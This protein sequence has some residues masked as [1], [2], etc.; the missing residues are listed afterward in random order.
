M[1]KESATVGV[2]S[3]TVMPESY[4]II[5][6]GRKKNPK[7]MPLSIP[8]RKCGRK[9]LCVGPP[10]WGPRGSTTGVSAHNI[11]ARV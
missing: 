6:G 11:G 8:R 4:N 3:K 10:P 2:S 9:F 1:E 5:G 7:M